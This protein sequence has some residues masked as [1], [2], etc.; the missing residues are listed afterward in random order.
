MVKGLKFTLGILLLILSFWN[1]DWPLLFQS[2]KKVNTAWFILSIVMVFSGLFLRVLRWRMLLHHY[3]IRLPLRQLLRAYFLGQAANIVLFFRGGELI[4]TWQAHQAE[5]DD[6]APIMIS[7]GLEKYLDLGM[8]ALLSAALAMTLPNGIVPINNQYAN[9]F[10]FASIILLV[11][12]IFLPELWG[13]FFQKLSQHRKESLFV[14]KTNQIINNSLWLRKPQ[15]TL[16]LG[17]LSVILWVVM[18]GTNL[19]LFRALSLSVPWQAAGLV[20][21]LV[22]IGVLPALMPG[23]V[24]PFTYFAQLGLIP[25]MVNSSEALAFAL[26]LYVVITMPPLFIAAGILFIDAKI[27]LPKT[28]RMNVNKPN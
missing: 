22:F 20:M 14:E 2:V 28:M 19:F 7:I 12:I 3:E 26:L 16:R 17:G 23:N 24:G 8:L 27:G 13:K 18:G 21:F 25:F 15:Y 4:R 5:K 11:V 9:L 6:L 1:V 10:I